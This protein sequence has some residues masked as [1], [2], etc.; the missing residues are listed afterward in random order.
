MNSSVLIVDDEENL[1]VLFD[2]ILTKEGFHVKTASDADRALH[3]LDEE[4]FDMAILDIQMYPMDGIRL[5]SELRKRSPSTA[6]IMTTA[7]PA[8]DTLSE[9]IKHGADA[10]LAKPVDLDEL[11]NVAR[12]LGGE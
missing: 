11:K 3:L 4:T 10:L 6:V 9:C 8:P 7:Y 12:S 1:L 2:W 5:L